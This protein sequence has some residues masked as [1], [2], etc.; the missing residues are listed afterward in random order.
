MDGTE[1]PRQTGGRRMVNSRFVGDESAAATAKPRVA[2]K[3]E[4]TEGSVRRAG[5]AA[6]DRSTNAPDT[7]GR[8]ARTAVP[9]CA[10]SSGSSHGRGP[11]L[12]SRGNGGPALRY[13]CSVSSVTPGQPVV[14]SGSPLVGVQPGKC[15]RATAVCCW[16]SNES[17]STCVSAARPTRAVIAL[18]PARAKHRPNGGIIHRN[19][20]ESKKKRGDSTALS[21]LSRRR[22]PGLGRRRRGRLR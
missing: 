12:G 5:V 4:A 18:E 13:R 10:I 7:R 22:G 9:V 8:R 17:G 3:Q 14:R 11:R 1:R 6:R 15:A 21:G 2:G 16:V 19:C 20:R